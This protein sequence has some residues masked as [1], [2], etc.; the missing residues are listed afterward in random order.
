MEINRHEEAEA[1]RSHI[2]NLDV[3]LRTR[4]MS[5]VQKNKINNIKKLHENALNTWVVKREAEAQAK[6]DKCKTSIRGRK[7]KKVG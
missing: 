2:F 7:S 4:R 3:I 5:P 6:R 1:V